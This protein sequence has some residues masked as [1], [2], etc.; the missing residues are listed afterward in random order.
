MTRNNEIAEE[1]VVRKIE[2]LASSTGLN[3]NE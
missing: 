2:K 3:N 1:P